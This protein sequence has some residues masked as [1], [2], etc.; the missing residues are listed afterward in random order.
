MYGFDRIKSS[1][2]EYQFSIELKRFST[3]SKSCFGFLVSECLEFWGLW[4]LKLVVKSILSVPW[5]VVTLDREDFI[6]LYPWSAASSTAEA[7]P[8]LKRLC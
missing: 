1:N 3:L 5:L 8:L 4:Y 2:P 7:M 6:A